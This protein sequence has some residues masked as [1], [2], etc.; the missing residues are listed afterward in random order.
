MKIQR[1]REV[2][3][4]PRDHT[5]GKWQSRTLNPALF[6]T[7]ICALNCLVFCAL[8]CSI[9]LFHL[10]VGDLWLGDYFIPSCASYSIQNTIGSPYLHGV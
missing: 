8:S 10:S 7:R 4:L 1:L 2:K 3:G 5:A 6:D 9:V